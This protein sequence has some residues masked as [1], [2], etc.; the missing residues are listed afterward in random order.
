MPDCIFGAP[1]TGTY[2]FALVRRD[3]DPRMKVEERNGT[4][5]NKS[6][7]VKWPEGLPLPAMRGSFPNAKIG[8]VMMMFVSDRH[9]RSRMTKLGWKDVTPEWLAHHEVDAKP[10]QPARRG[11]RKP[12][13]VVPQPPSVDLQ[14]VKP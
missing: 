12:P 13:P 5:I 4:H 10:K 7:C 9:L 11:G 3:W 1:D 6:R 8:A 2:N 14:S